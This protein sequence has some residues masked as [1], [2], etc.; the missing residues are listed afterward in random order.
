MNDIY[1]QNVP[2]GITPTNIFK[3]FVVKKINNYVSGLCCKF[4]LAF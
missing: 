2:N 4:M 1:I 3:V